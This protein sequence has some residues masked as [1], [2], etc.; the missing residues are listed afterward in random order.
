MEQYSKTLQCLHHHLSFS[1]K[2]ACDS[3]PCLNNGTCQN[4][5]TEKTFRCLCP[6]GFGGKLC[7]NGKNG[8]KVCNCSFLEKCKSEKIFNWGGPMIFGW[9][10]RI[11]AR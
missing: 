6:G 9:M 7:E 5:F 4:G 3:A 2:N 1:L 11:I 8:V 10:T